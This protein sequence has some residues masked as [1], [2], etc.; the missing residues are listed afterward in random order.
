[1]KKIIFSLMVSIS[2]FGST[3]LT[4]PNTV[5]L[6]DN[7][8]QNIE[9][10][11]ETLSRMDNDLYMLDLLQDIRTDVVLVITQCVNTKDEASLY[12]VALRDVDETIAILKVI[13]K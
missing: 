6:C 2:L 1:M 11:A 4:L 13:T 8:K 5:S 3:T 12:D 10:N 7:V 9:S